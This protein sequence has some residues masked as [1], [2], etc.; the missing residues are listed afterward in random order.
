MNTTRTIRI[1]SLALVSIGFGSLLSQI[2][3]IREFLVSFYGNELSIGII[4]ACWLIWI[5]VGSTAGNYIVKK[6]QNISLLFIVLLIVSPCI[7]VLQILSVKFVRIFLHAAPG[8]Y[9]S[10]LQLLGFAGAV[11][12][13]GCLLW[14]ML[15]TLGAKLISPQKEQLWRG[16]NRAYVLESIGSVAGG[17]LFS[18]VLSSTLS[19]FQIL[20]ILACIVWTASVWLLPVLKNSHRVTCLFGF[21]IITAVLLRPLQVLEHRINAYQWSTINAQLTY[22]QSIDTK[23]QNLSLLKME[24]QY[25]LYSDGH[26]L[27]NI[28]NT[29]DAEVFVHSI[30]IQRADAHNVL[31]VGGGFNGTLKELLK[32]PIQTIDYIETDPGLHSFVE[33]VLDSLNL[34][35]LHHPLVHMAFTDGREFIRTTEKKYDVILINIGE[36]STAN[37]N[38]FFTSEFYKLCFSRLNPDGMLACSFPSSAEYITDE[39]KSLNA[40]LYQSFKQSCKQILLIPGDHA[41]M[42]G[43][44]SEKPF[45]ENPDSLARIYSDAGISAEYFSRYMYQERMLSERIQYLTRTLAS[46]QDFQINTDTHPVAYYYDVQIWNH[47]L[48]DNNHLF[49]FITRGKIFLAGFLVSGL[50]L[51]IVFTQRKKIEKQART[52][53]A[54]IMTCGGMIGMALNLLLILNF[55]ETF[56]S[57]Y[58]MIGAISALYLLGLGCGALLSIVL[59]KKYSLQFIQIAALGILCCG[60]LTLPFLLPLLV[61]LHSMIFTFLAVWIFSALIGILFGIVNRQYTFCSANPGS[62]YAYD[63]LGS[64]FGALITCSILLPVL[65]MHELSYILVFFAGISLILS[66]VS[67]AQE[68]NPFA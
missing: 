43:S 30:M 35:A 41:V 47:F 23:Y 58:E 51:L 52:A 24:N 54:V 36:P 68:T 9:L 1:N 55:Q 45:M 21:V 34:L 44:R 63:V 56:G 39:M 50:F 5:G 15:F 16:I 46:V 48:Q 19:T 49:S 29:Y 6:M 18:F 66:I 7:S 61:S 53:L 28:P 3:L 38:R 42:L 32:Y 60:I 20:C 33:P 65:G 31:L 59:S 37:T 17:L 57:M 40:S 27:Y 62:I 13:V 26:P 10:M 12:S 64:S 4:F 67:Q 14:G 11:L 8:E 2:L 22:I 25:T